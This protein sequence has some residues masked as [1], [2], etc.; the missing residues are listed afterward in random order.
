MFKSFC[1]SWCIKN[2]KVEIDRK[3]LIKI[4]ISIKSVNLFTFGSYRSETV[5]SKSFVGKVLL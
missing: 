3:K 5:N 4:H 2:S 1:W